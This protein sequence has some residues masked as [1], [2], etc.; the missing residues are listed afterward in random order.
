MSGHS[1][2]WDCVAGPGDHS[3]SIVIVVLIWIGGDRAGREPDPD[4]LST[5]QRAKV[6]SA[7]ENPLLWN[8]MWPLAGV[9]DGSLYFDNQPNMLDQFLVN[10]NMATGDAPIK[11]DPATAPILKPPAMVTPGVYPKPIPL[12]GMGKPVNQNGFSDHFQIT[13]TITEV[14]SVDWRYPCSATR[15]LCHRFCDR[16]Q[17]RTVVPI[18]VE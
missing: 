14:D 10:K 15:D 7:R 3:A 6:T 8:L 13:L 4:A 2:T 11:V 9:P 5:R 12:S 17:P 1:W 18:R 16:Q